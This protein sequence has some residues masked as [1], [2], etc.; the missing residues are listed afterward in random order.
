MNATS[1]RRR[2][3]AGTYLVVG[4]FALVLAFPFYWALLTALKT[5][6]DLYDLDNVPYFFNEPPTL[7]HVGYL[8]TE[9]L[10]L[11]WASNTALVGLLVVAVTLLLALPAGYILSRRGDP[12]LRRLGMGMF[13]TYLVPSTLLFLPL[14]RAVSL[15][16]LQNSRWSLVLVYPSLT[17]PFCT[18]LF[19]G[20]FKTIPREIEEAALVDGCTRVQAFRTVLVPMSVPAIVAAVIFAFTTATNEFL[21]ALTFITRASQKTI[22]IGVP[23]DLIRGDVFY[24]GSLMAGAVMPSV[25]VGLLYALL[26]RRVMARLAAGGR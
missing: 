17:V 21:Y 2:H 1:G 20:F 18:W 12:W 5:T 16:G 22:S 23:T 11:R 24:W 14:A 26:V 3:R 13:L 15:M 8:L 6:G 19:S 4:S 9:T 7:E 10:Y 25:V